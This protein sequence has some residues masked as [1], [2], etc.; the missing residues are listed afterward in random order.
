MLS[1]T[2]F[3]ATENSSYG[4][5]RQFALLWFGSLPR[6]T[7]SESP[8]PTLPPYEFCRTL[9]SKIHSGKMNGATLIVRLREDDVNRLKQT[10]I[11]ATDKKTNSFEPSFF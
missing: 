4:V 11:L 7:E 3:A 8:S 1:S 9:S 10:K 6:S 2:F 5:W